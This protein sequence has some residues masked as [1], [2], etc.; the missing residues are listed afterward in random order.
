MVGLRLCV[1]ECRANAPVFKTRLE[2]CAYMRY[3][4]TPILLFYYFLFSKDE[5]H[6][7]NGSHTGIPKREECSTRMFV[8]KVYWRMLKMGSK[9]KLSF[10][11]HSFTNR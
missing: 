1:L 8:Y 7:N 6:T 4:K 5:R 10:M 3:Y 11:T 2:K 9:V